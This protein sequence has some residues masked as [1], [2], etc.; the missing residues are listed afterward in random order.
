MVNDLGDGMSE[1]GVEGYLG[2]CVAG[3][4]GV[5]IT[6]ICGGCG[7]CVDCLWLRDDPM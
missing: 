3:G 2:M 7:L 4:D 1:L 5:G 6:T